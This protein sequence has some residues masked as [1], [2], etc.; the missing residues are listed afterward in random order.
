MQLLDLPRI[1]SFCTA[2]LVIGLRATVLD[3]PVF[4]LLIL[5]PS[6]VPEFFPVVW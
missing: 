5:I 4:R 3:F 6:V 1:K 2:I